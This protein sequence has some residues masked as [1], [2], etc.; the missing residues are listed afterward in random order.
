MRKGFTLIELLIVVAIIAILAAIAVPNFLEAQTRA[1]VVRVK[2]DMR[3]VGVALESYNVDNN[4]YMPA[5]F[6]G[7]GPAFTDPHHAWYGWAQNFLMVTSTG[8]VHP[9]NDL[10]NRLT[11]PIAYISS[12][13]IDP[14][15]TGYLR[16]YNG[17]A[18]GWPFNIDTA[19]FLYAS[20]LLKPFNLT[21][22]G[23]PYVEDNAHITYRNV[24]YYLRSIGPALH[25][26]DFAIYDP[27]NGT[28]SLGELLWLNT[29]GPLSK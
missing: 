12:I 18:I 25:F 7:G 24:S 21:M 16:Y 26:S 22:S 10:G 20:D 6:A 1:K 23:T 15:W 3:S 14:F 4:K 29:V 11:S 2:A 13:P 8:G 9:Y 28:T 27:T 5:Y 19:S 17:V